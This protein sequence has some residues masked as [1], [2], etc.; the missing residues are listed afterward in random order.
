MT[1]LPGPSETIIILILSSHIFMEELLDIENL[2]DAAT[3]C[4]ER[5]GTGYKLRRRGWNRVSFQ[6][7]CSVRRKSEISSG[8][9]KLV[10]KRIAKCQ[11]GKVGK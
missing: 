5:S 9:W 10:N 1:E 4:I 3:F 7:V 11:Q 8:E 2:E 6:A